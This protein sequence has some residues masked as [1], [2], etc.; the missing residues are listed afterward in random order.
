MQLGGRSLA[1]LPEMTGNLGYIV[2][3]FYKCTPACCFPLL[4][5]YVYPALGICFGTVLQHVSDLKA[6]YRRV[7]TCSAVLLLCYVGTLA[8]AGISIVPFYSLENDA[9]YNQS[10][11]STVFSFLL[12][13]LILSVSH[14]VSLL[15]KDTAAGRFVKQTSSHLTHIFVI[16]WLLIGLLVAILK[17]FDIPDIPLPFI[18]PVGVLLTLVTG[19]ILQLYLKKKCANQTQTT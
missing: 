12:I 13:C 8:I 9:F 1:C 10:F 4:Q 2:G 17:V 15:I 7:G 19:F 6:W 3:H 5:W 14:P 16:Q 11:L 18:V